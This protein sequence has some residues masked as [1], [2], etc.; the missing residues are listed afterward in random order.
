MRRLAGAAVALA[1]RD[2]VRLPDLALL[3]AWGDPLPF[4]L[5]A[6]AGP[7]LLGRLHESSLAGGDRRARGAFYTPAAVADRLVRW[8]AP[9]RAQVV[10]DPACG[11]GAFLLAA[12]RAGVA[13]DRLVGIDIDPVAAAVAEA[14]VCLAAGG[15]PP[16][17]AVADALVDPWP[18]EADVVVG[19]PPFLGQLKA[20]TA[21][22]RD[23][24]ATVGRTGYADEAVLF[25]RRSVE[26]ARPGGA[27]ALLQPLSLLS[28]AGAAPT[29]AALAPLVERVWLPEA[30][31]FD[32]AAVSVC[33]VVVRPD[34]TGPS[35]VATGGA[36]WADLLADAHG[37]PAVDLGDGPVLGEWCTVTAG[38]RDEY[39]GLVPHVAESAEVPTGAP[40]VTSGLIDP[41]RCRW[42]EVPARF[43][44]RRWQAPVVDRPADGVPKVLV[45][46]QTRVVEAVVDVAGSWVP[47]TPV[48]SVV[49]SDGDVWRTLAVL[50]APPVSAWA[51]RRTAGTGMSARALKLTAAHVRAIPSPPD[52]TAWSASAAALAAGDLDAAGVAGCEAYGVDV[53]DWW[54]GLLP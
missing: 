33:A 11:G 15:R 1:Q 34:R 9:W 41:N 40:L 13:V 44:K 35:V 52:A 32:D 30:Q 19:N 25:L 47:V 3:S 43:A 24:A 21:R 7:E 22:T 28:A 26:L 20:S 46:T 39:Y 29:R 17:I 54:R 2:G 27:V 37:V 23:R 5:P 51:L 12:M 6:G 38:F 10:C 4:D 45:A 53:L 49:P 36:P 8:T 50:L 31:L 48:V 14:A 42:G 16:R 18:V